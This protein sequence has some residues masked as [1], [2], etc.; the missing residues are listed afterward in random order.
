M[1]RACSSTSCGCRASPSPEPT[2]RLQR[3]STTA[4]TSRPAVHPGGHEPGAAELPRRVP[5]DPKTLHDLGLDE[6]EVTFSSGATEY[7]EAR[8][9]LEGVGLMALI[10]KSYEI[11]RDAGRE[12]CSR[13]CSRP[14]TTQFAE[15]WQAEAGLKTYGEAVADILEL[16]TADGETFDTTA[17]EWRAFASQASFFEVREKLE[18][19]RHPGHLGSRAAQDPGPATT[20]SRAE[21]TTR[22][23]NAG[24]RALCRPVVDGDENSGPRGRP[25]VRRPDP[26]QLS[27]QVA[28][29][30][31]S[32]SFNWDTTGL[33]DDE[34]RR[35]PEEARKLGFVF[36][37]ITYAGHQIDGLA[38][39]D[40]PPRWGRT[41]AG[42]GAPAAQVQTT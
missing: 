10:R 5:R 1:P 8:A 11:A 7:T 31:L 23:Q 40:S 30:Q 28:G 18:L 4:A 36:N 13:A 24:C 27:R 9:W 17:E 15:T 14:M 2:P 42:A 34:M 20:R 16:P 25:Q 22:W 35:F 41:D 26:C 6:I 38:A 32:P 3:S 19:T 37:F 39:E 33:T 21:S 12:L 29:L